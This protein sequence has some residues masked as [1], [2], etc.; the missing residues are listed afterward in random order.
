MFLVTDTRGYLIIEREIVKRLGCIHFPE[1]TLPR[2][3]RLPKM[4]TNLKA[5]RM[6]TSGEEE[7]NEK[8]QG[9]KCLG[10][11]LLDGVVLIHG[12]RHSLPIMKEYLLKEYSDVSGV[13]TPQGKEYHITLKKNCIG[14]MP[15]KVSP[16]QDQGSI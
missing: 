6:K 14:P 10:V 9:L 5:I 2:L 7:V 1:I 15:P 3:I 4:H 11:Q 8:D 13:G 12:K 16:S